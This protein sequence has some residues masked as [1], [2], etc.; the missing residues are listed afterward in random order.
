L[1]GDLLLRI[2]LSRVWPHSP[3]SAI[4]EA[5]SAR[6]VTM[7]RQVTIADH[8]GQIIKEKSMEKQNEF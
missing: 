5:D 1:Y 7:S 2:P 3:L 6:N 8:W 4:A